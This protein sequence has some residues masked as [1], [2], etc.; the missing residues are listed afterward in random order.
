M[1]GPP[2]PKA[3][4]QCL[5]PRRLAAGRR[6]AG[7]VA[8]VHAEAASR[9]LTMS[10]SACSI[11]STPGRACAT[12]IFQR[13]LATA[14]NDWQ[15]EKWTSKDSRLKGSDRGRQR[16]RRCRGRRNPQ[17][18]RRQEFRPG[19]AAQPQRRAAGPAPLLADLRGGAGGR[20][21]GRR[22]RLRL[23]RQSDHGIRLAELLHRGDGRPFA[24]PADRA[25]QHRA[26]RR[27][28]AISES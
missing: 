20:P 21:S 19:A 12:T 7:F 26:G 23:R 8:V 13:A 16:G 27:V 2:Y 3:Q 9:S 14:I 25:R 1:E 22:A 15:I 6:P 18:R 17:A 10:R 4:P 11:R 5:A 24:V 28:R